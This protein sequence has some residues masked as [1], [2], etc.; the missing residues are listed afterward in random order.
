MMSPLAQATGPGGRGMC[1]ALRKMAQAQ[2]PACDPACLGICSGLDWRNHAGKDPSLTGKQVVLHLRNPV[3]SFIDEWCSIP[4][5]KA[6]NMA[7]KTP[8]RA[9]LIQGKVADVEV[10][11]FV[12]CVACS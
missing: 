5:A 6:R 1:G 3:G 11:R 7:K 4:S 12:A 8:Y 2:H 10:R 9:A